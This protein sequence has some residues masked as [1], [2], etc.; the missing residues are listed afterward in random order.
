M[1]ITGKMGADLQQSISVKLYLRLKGSLIGFNEE[2]IS[3][4]V[5]PEK[6]ITDNDV[7]FASFDKS[8]RTWVRFFIASYINDYYELGYNVDWSNFIRLTPGPMYKKEELMLFPRTDLVK[9]IFSHRRTIGRFFPGRK[10]VY[11]TR[12]F[13]DILVSFYFFH[14]NR[15]W[16]DFENMDVN[17]FAMSAFD[18]D[19]AI[20]RI[21]YFSRKLEKASEY[22]VVPYEELRQET[23]STF[24]RIIEFT[25]Y[26]FD[27]NVFRRAMEHSSFE[28]MQK[29]E[30]KGRGDVAREKLHA[31]RGETNKYKEYL[32]QDAISFVKDRLDK[33][34]TGAL[35]KYYLPH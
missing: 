30:L 14:K 2:I 18:L 16:Y 25:P 35:K 11:I 5:H 32:S 28:S 7:I 4:Y 22:M 26:E 27:K 6:K 3:R 13:L 34:M 21:N 9:P 8:G 24:R 12:N 20:S 19:E 33:K 10:V 1:E 17:R 31:R 29:L 23:E 15:N